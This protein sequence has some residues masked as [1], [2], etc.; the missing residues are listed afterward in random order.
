MPA[1]IPLDRQTDSQTDR[2]LI[3]LIS[4]KLQEGDKKCVWEDDPILPKGF[5]EKDR[6]VV[7]P[8]NVLHD[9]PL[10]W[11]CLK[12]ETRVQCPQ[13]ARLFP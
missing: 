11:L 13:Q 12:A 7:G 2:G 10:L 1:A 6:N 9:L 8:L 3:A 4:L 5:H